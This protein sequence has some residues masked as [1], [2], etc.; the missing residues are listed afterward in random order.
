V[1]DVQ[2]PLRAN[3]RG[4]AAWSVARVMSGRHD[5]LS[6]G[7]SSND[8]PHR[9]VLAGTWVAPW[10]RWSTEV[11]SYYVGESGRPFAYVAFG[12]LG[13]GDLN[14]DGSSANDP[15]YVP[16]DVFDDTE[17]RFSGFSESGSSDTSSAAQAQRI[18]LQRSAF[19]AFIEATPCMRRQRGRILARNSCR[20][21]WSSTTIASIRQAIPLSGHAFEL[22]LEVFNVLNL[23]NADWGRDREAVPALLE[24]VGQIAE[25]SGG[26]QPVF[27]FSGDPGWVSSTGESSFQLQLAARYRF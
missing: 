18:R 19:D 23:L 3:T 24:H 4:T 6:T 16:R 13:R 20:E 5:D 10:T 25:A 26:S 8:I 22:Q 17:I 1:R 27:R 14:A 11:S 2:T 21:P 7:I 12:T 15:V 9:V